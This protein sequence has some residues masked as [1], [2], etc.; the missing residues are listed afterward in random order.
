MAGGY[1]VPFLKFRE[2]NAN[3]FP[4]AGGKLHSYVAGTNDP[5]ATYFDQDLA[6]GHENQNPTILD[7]SGRANVWIPSGVAYKFVLKDALDNVIYTQDRVQIPAG[8]GGGSTTTITGDVIPPGSI[9]PYGGETP[10]ATMT[11][12]PPRLSWLLCNGDAVSRSVYQSLFNAIGDKYGHGNEST[13]FNLPNLKERFPIGKADTGDANTVGKSGGTFHHRHDGGAHTHPILD[14]HHQIAPHQHQVRAALWGP[15]VGGATGDR[16]S[17][18]LLTQN[19]LNPGQGAG[20]S[21]PGTNPGLTEATAAID[22]G[23][24]LPAAIKAESGGTEQTGQADPPYLVV[25]FII[26]T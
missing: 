16:N 8:G 6:V 9:F 21:L 14:H 18:P 12:E 13:T 25:T 2:D 7:A 4:L 17:E 26:K 22:T 19:F 24:P 23:S 5:L 3:G 11:G 15:S 10:P 20:A 1:P